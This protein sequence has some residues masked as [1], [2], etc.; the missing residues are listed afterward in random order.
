MR[1]RREVAYGLGAYAAY[2]IVRRTVWHDEG[3]D[4][5]RINARRVRQFE[6]RL[7]VDIEP[8][9]QHLAMR[10]PRLVDVFNA[11]YAAGNVSLSVGWLIRLHHRRDPQYGRERAAALAAFVGSLPIFAAFPTAPPRT[12]D[13][14][15]DTLAERGVRLDH[16]MLVRFYNP[17]AAMPSQHVAFAVVTGFGLARRSRSTSARRGWRAYPVGVALAVMA[18]GNHF[19]ADVAAGAA[20]GAIARRVTR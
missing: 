19:V 3:R 14:F 6:E 8:T 11:G 7:G 20:L 4:R 15:V 13:G 9:L 10:M 16:P 12:L 5:A 17:I 1:A 2:L 18:T